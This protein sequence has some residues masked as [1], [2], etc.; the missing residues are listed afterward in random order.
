MCTCDGVRCIEGE[1]I[2]LFVSTPRTGIARVVYQ[3]ETFEV[4]ELKD[5]HELHDIFVGLR[6]VIRV[7]ASF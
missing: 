3:E 7:L 4:F 6:Y 1:D 2:V 5:L